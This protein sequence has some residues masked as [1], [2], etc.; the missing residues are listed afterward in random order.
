MSS[1][2]V[3]VYGGF[4]DENTFFASAE[5]DEILECGVDET[6]VFE[7]ELVGAGLVEQSAPRF[8][9]TVNL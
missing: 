6:N 5:L 3:K 9:R 1:A 4:D 7:Y 8:V 2:P